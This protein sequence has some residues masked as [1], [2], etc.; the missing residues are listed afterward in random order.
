MFLFWII[1]KERNK[2]A[3]ENNEKEDQ[4][5]K[6]AFM[7]IFWEW[8]RMYKGGSSFPFALFGLLVPLYTCI[9][10]CTLLLGII[11][12]FYLCLSKKKLICKF[13]VPTT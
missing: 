3:F 6:Q 4:A 1:R 9:S 7:L 12:I 13:V 11:N 8:V 2:R 5:I 10:L